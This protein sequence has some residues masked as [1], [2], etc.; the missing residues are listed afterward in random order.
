MNP[1]K[2][3][4]IFTAILLVLFCVILW[5]VDY[6]S[7]GIPEYI[8]NTKYQTYTVTMFAIMAL[9]LIIFQKFLLKQH[10]SVKMGKLILWSVLVCLFSQA[11]YQIFRQVW[12]LRYENNDKASD[13]FISLGSSIILSLFIA[14]S[15]A[16]ELKKTNAILKTLAPLAVLGLLFVF[17]EYFPNITW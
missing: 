14:S 6:S 15:I 8:N 17:K 12:I 9:V 1:K 13:Y 4:L 16:F 11:I 7:F 2:L 3:I 10:P 5:L